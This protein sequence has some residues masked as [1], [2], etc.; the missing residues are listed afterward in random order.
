MLRDACNR[1]MASIAQ[2][3]NEARRCHYSEGFQQMRGLRGVVICNKRNRRAIRLPS[4]C[5][6][7]KREVSRNVR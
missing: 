3:S 6:G 4:R 5:E 2:T 7:G 1:A